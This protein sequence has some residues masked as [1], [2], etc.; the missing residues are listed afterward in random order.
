M[1]G[2]DRLRIFFFCLQLDLSVTW[3]VEVE[4]DACMEWNGQRK[5]ASRWAEGIALVWVFRL[6]CTM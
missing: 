1:T 2:N 5:N 4:W 3:G 6:V